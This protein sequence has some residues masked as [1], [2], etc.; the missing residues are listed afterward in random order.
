MKP[1]TLLD[2][3]EIIREG[4]AE[5]ALA[6]WARE[7]LSHALALAHLALGMWIRNNFIHGEGSPL[8][9]RIKESATL[10]HPLAPIWHPDDS[11]SLVLEALWRVLNG[12]ECPTITDLVKRSANGLN[13]Q[14][15][16]SGFGDGQVRE[17]A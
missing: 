6:E 3:V 13:R 5:E 8:A 17:E 10:W 11:S 12:E 1:E 15:E 14:G 2:A 9:T 16:L 4:F 7:P